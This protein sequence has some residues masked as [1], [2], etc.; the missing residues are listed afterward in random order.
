MQGVLNFPLPPWRS[1]AFNLKLEIKRF[2]DFG[3]TRAGELACGGGFYAFYTQPIWLLFLL[4]IKNS[5]VLSTLPSSIAGI[6]MLLF[7]WHGRF[8]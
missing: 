6:D 1:R 8:G 4:R 3:V 5:R 7:A 2:L